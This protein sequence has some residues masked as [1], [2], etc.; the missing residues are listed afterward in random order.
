MSTPKL[1][2]VALVALLAWQLLAAP[3]Q[4]KPNSA[5]P[6]VTCA[7]PGPATWAQMSILERAAYGWCAAGEVGGR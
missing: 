7:N 5:R 2:L 4:T 1:I 6:G 3:V